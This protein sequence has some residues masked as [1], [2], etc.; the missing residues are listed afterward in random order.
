MLEVAESRA[1]QGELVPAAKVRVTEQGA[2]VTEDYG[3]EVVRLSNI[4]KK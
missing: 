2:I 3:S 4:T 1:G